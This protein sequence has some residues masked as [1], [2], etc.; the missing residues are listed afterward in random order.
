MKFGC[1]M[2]LCMKSNIAAFDKH[3]A[4]NCNCLW[5]EPFIPRYLHSKIKNKWY[6]FHVVFFCF[7]SDKK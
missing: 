7:R 4:A 5:V 2:K 6:V 3:I 1:N